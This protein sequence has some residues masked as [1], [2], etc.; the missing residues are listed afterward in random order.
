MG[1]RFASRRPCEPSIALLRVSGS[2][3]ALAPSRALPG[4]AVARSS[5][6]ADLCSGVGDPGFGRHALYRGPVGIFTQWVADS[7]AL[8]YSDDMNEAIARAHLK[9]E[10]RDFLRVIAA[11][12]RPQSAFWASLVFACGGPERLPTAEERSQLAQWAAE[13]LIRRTTW[14]S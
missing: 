11:G 7:R 8:P 12:S 10:P 5:L 3:R 14:G 6:A 1:A 9:S 13:E 4:H 2:L